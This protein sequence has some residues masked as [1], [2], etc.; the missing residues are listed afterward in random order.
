M[1]EINDLEEI[2]KILLDI[3]IDFDAFCE[4]NNLRYFL[5]FGTL[6]GAVRHQG[7]IP[8]DDDIDVCMPRPDYERFLELTK[9]ELNGHL[10][11]LSPGSPGYPF[12]FA[13]V[14]DVRTKMKEPRLLKKNETSLFMDV[15]PIDGYPKDEKEGEKHFAKI[16]SIR[17]FYSKGL[18]L[19][20]TPL[21]TIGK[22]IVYGTVNFFTTENYFPRKLI[23]LAKKYSFEESATLAV[24]GWTYGKKG[25]VEKKEY[26]NGQ[27]LKFEGHYFWCPGNYEE[28]LQRLYGDYMK[29]PPVEKRV[30]RHVA[31]VWWL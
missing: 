14:I 26:L 5:G 1:R 3:L 20:A 16:K 19:G 7:F 11:T 13:K 4:E 17:E 8:W 21:K 9:V 27:K 23:E 31:D 6:L 28:H 24:A 10:K 22:S 15:F 2:Q 25:K 12:P 29:L 18:F 30:K